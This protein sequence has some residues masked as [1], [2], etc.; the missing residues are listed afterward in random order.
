M[1][2]VHN[3][4][5]LDVNSIE[6][7]SVIIAKQADSMSRYIDITLQCAGEEIVVGNND[8]VVLM[9]ADKNTEE[10]IAIVDCT[11]QNGVITAELSESL[12]AVPGKLKCEIVIYGTD[13]SVLTSANFIVIV[14][15]RI[16]GEV[17]E[18]EADF[19]ALQSALSDVSSTSNRI[20]AVQETVNTR[21]QPI[22]LGGT[23]ASDALSAAQSL[24]VPSLAVA[25][26][27]TA[28]A[29]L[30]EFTVP[31]TYNAS[32]DVSK[33]LLNSPTVSGFKMYVLEQQTPSWRAQLLIVASKDEIW[34]RGSSAANT[35]SSWRKITDANQISSIA[36]ANYIG[37]DSGKT[38]SDG[39]THSRPEMLFGTDYNDITSTG[40]YILRGKE[41][42]PTANAPDGCNTD[43]V[44]YVLVF[45]YTNDYYTQIAVN[46]RSA[47]DIYIRS[48]QSGEWTAW[49]KL[50]TYDAL[51]PENGIWVP[52]A[53]IGTLTVNTANY[54]YNGNTV[55]VTA[56]IECGDDI[57]KSINISGLPVIAKSDS[58][59]C[60]CIVDSD[61]VLSV[62]VN[63]NTL[64]VKSS[65]ALAGKTIILEATYII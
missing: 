14:S 28:D 33:T 16:D 4:L 58:A 53:K 60:G 62:L 54:T 30:N 64:T 57:T 7:K 56:R 9:A 55:T 22:S 38:Y 2:T 40:L 5:I 49:K 26:P 50:M 24:K 36:I 8:R 20:D 32:S 52:A 10:T 48:Y 27:I 59:G 1:K 13:S 51:M 17:I 19:S 3:K 31:G 18:R 43:N 42:Y 45:K 6:N 34:Y 25:T 65:T 35:Y 41:T 39:T 12:L 44:F 23:G 21:V 37:S 11:V 29:D 47:N 63:E 46:I 15:E 61:T